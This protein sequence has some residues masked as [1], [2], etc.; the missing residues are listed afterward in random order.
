M[1]NN[2]ADG[3]LVERKFRDG[4]QQSWWALEV[5]AGPYGSE[6]TERAVIATTDPES[7]PDATTWYVVT[8]VPVPGSAVA[9]LSELEAAS[10]QDIVRLYGLRM[11]IEPALETRQ[12]CAR[13]VTVSGEKRPGHPAALATG[14][15]CLLVLLVS[16]LSSLLWQDG[17]CRR[18]VLF[19]YLPTPNFIIHFLLLHEI[20]NAHG[21]CAIMHK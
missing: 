15:L 17:R 12:A 18:S 10:L 9:Q 4:S 3:S 13:L 19:L 11:W 6:K 16:R 21:R 8:N 20:E 7:L 1:L 2:P 5:Q 14:L